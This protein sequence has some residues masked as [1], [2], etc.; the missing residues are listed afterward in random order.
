MR[1]NKQ[2]KAARLLTERRVI[3]VEAH[4]R[5]V[6]GWVRG[7][8]GTYQVVHEAGMWSCPCDCRQICSHV[9]ALQMITETI[10][11]GAPS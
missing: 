6:S 11:L 4:G 3:V 8:T 5:Y 1:E 2:A 10:K 9:I 7:D